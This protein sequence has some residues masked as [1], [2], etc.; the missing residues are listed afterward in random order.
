MLEY[1]FFGEASLRGFTALLDRRG[2]PWSARDDSM[3]GRIVAFPDDLPDALLDEI[4]ACHDELMARQSA[5]AEQDP[6]LV[7][8]RVVG[9][10]ITLADGRACTVRLDGATGN[11]L[12]QHFAPEQAQQLVQAIARSL[13]APLDGPLCRRASD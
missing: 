9:I 12:L 11:L 2:V 1:V 8:H 10:D 4:E 7:Q 5:E 3:A 13:D 6:A